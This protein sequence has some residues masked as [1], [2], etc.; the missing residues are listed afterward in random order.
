MIDQY[1]SYLFTTGMFR[2]GTTLLA[3]MLNS[4]SNIVLAA[5]VLLE[6]IKSFRNELYLQNGVLINKLNRPLEDHFKSN[7]HNLKKILEEKNFDLTIKHTNLTELTERTRQFSTTSSELFGKNLKAFEGKKFSDILY[8][9]LK[10]IDTTYGKKNASVLGFKSVWSEQYVAPFLN[11]FPKKGKALFIIRDPRA[12]FASNFVK[13]SHLYPIEFLTKQW[14]KSVVFATLYSK[15][16]PNLTEKCLIIKYEDLVSKSNT[17]VKKITD[18]LN[19]DF[20][21]DMLNPSLYKNGKNKQWIQNTSHGIS[22]QQLTTSSVEKWKDIFDEKTQRFIEYSC[23]P[24]M[25]LMG[26]KTNLVNIDN[27]DES[28]QYPM[29]NSSNTAEWIKEFYPNELLKNSKWIEGIEVDNKQRNKI[30]LDSIKNT[31]EMDEKTITE[32]FIDK[33]YFSFLLDKFITNKR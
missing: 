6:F 24:E 8:Q 19:L 26:Y 2:S 28:I 33:R 5:D 22:H 14:R 18:F 7:F 23:F 29:D 17:T 4:H 3:R 9:L 1:S 31:K 32:F 11:Q 30:L 12:V 21:E 16:I 25:Q 15:I 13:P 10:N 20:E 27:L